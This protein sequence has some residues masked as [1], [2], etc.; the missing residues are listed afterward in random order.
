VG[1][2]GIGVGAGPYGPYGA[3]AYDPY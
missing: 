3:Y 1:R 2:V